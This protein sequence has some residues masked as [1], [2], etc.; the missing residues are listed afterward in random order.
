MPFANQTPRP[1]IKS[2]V[3]DLKPNQIGV[4]G[5]FRSGKWIYV[6][7]GDIRQRLLNHLNGDNECITRQ[8][9]THWVAELTNGDPSEREKALI[10]ELQPTC[11]QRV[12]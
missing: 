4:Y 10:L 11:N 7:K 2:D 8:L 5:I 9:P 6:G 3:E 12:G 1:F